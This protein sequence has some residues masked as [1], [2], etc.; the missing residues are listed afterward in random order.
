M[1]HEKTDPKLE[2]II[3]Q[4]DPEALIDV[5]LK[6]GQST[7]A[8]ELGRTAIRNIY[9]MVKSLQSERQPDFRQL[10]LLIPKLKYAA[11]RQPKLNQLT[12]S[13]IDAIWL[14]GSDIDRFKHFADFFEAVV[15]YHYAASEELKKKR[16]KP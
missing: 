4:G 3:S 10:K 5:A 12:E 6:L 7:A 1:A 13:L 14:V 9:G 2:K 8:E 15:A 16:S 11:A